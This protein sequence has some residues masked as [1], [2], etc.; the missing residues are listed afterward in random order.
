MIGIIDYYESSEGPCILISTSC[1][2]TL[3]KIREM[4]YE[5]SVGIQ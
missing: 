1:S 5:L 2:N 4:V 3:I